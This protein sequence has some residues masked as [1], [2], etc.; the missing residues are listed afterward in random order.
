MRGQGVRSLLVDPFR[1]AL[2]RLTGDTREAEGPAPQSSLSQSTGDAVDEW[3]IRR[4]VTT[5]LP[6]LAL[7]SILQMGSGSV[8]ETF[9]QQLL[10]QP[11]LLILVPVQIGTAGNL[12]S[13]MCSRMSTQLYLGTFELDPNNPELRATVGAIFGLAAT[14]F[15]LL[16]LSAWAIGQFLG[17]SLALIEVLAVSVISGMLLAVWVVIVSIVAIWASYR[18]GY[19]LDDTTIPVVTNVSDISGVLI[20]FA[21]VTV[22]F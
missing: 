7:L 8:L 17:G 21:V 10:T 18:L 12:G 22:V 5:M 2:D 1:D 4:I 3:S 9:E 6:L 15:V 16:G 20:L 11:S 13:I 19:N 14:V